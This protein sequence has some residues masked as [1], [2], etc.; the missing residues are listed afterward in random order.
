MERLITGAPFGAMVVALAGLPTAG[1]DLLLAGGLVAMAAARVLTERLT[2]V[3]L[4]LDLLLGCLVLVLSALPTANTT[5]VGAVAALLL[6]RPLAI[7]VVRLL[8]V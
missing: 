7:G 2:A 1:P 5:T 8:D 3:P 6:V 4:S